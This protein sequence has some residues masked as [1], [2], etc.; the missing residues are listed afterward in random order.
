MG[1]PHAW[2]APFAGEAFK[3]TFNA[4]ERELSARPST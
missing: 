1:G 3:S 2:A 4:L